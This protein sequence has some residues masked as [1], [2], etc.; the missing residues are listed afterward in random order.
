MYDTCVLFI[1]TVAII[2]KVELDN[3][4]RTFG[5]FRKTMFKFILSSLKFLSMIP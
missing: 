4:S 1:A 5:L 2:L 3:Y